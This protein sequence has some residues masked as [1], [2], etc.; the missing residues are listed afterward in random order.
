MRWQLLAGGDFRSL[1]KLSMWIAWSS[2]MSFEITTVSKQRARR[3]IAH[4]RRRRVC[5]SLFFHF[6]TRVSPSRGAPM[7]VLMRSAITV[8]RGLV[9][10]FLC[11]YFTAHRPL[12][13][14]WNVLLKHDGKK[15]M[16]GCMYFHTHDF[17]RGTHVWQYCVHLAWL[18]D[19]DWTPHKRDT[20][21]VKKK[22]HIFLFFHSRWGLVGR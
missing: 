16:W 8:S 22:K 9:G 6:D 5:V 1:A 15:H 11:I 2:K 14:G 4:L 21:K 12:V 7:S 3:S 17:R 10:L 18:L 13:K 19:T 20:E